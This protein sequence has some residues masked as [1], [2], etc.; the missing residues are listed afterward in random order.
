MGVAG[1]W[2][3]TKNSC[4]KRLTNQDLIC[5]FYALLGKFVRSPT[6]LS[7]MAS[8]PIR[9][10]KGVSASASMHPSGSSM[11]RMVGRARIQSFARSS[12]VAVVYFNRPCSHFSS[13]MVQTDPLSNAVN[14]L[15]ETHTGSPKV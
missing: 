2:E 3:V 15:A 10:T 14:A 11:P 1:L 8:T 6:L 9:P 5:R 13:S 7:R 12:F 4:D